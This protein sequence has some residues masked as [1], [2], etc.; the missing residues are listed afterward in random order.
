MELLLLVVAITLPNG[1][2]VG[3]FPK[4]DGREV[5]PKTLAGLDGS[6]CEVDPNADVGVVDPCAGVL[7]NVSNADSC[8]CRY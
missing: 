3:V 5:W 4:A 2:V 8:E 1:E 6:V 7:V